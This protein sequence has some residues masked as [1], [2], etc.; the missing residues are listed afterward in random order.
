MPY[1]THNLPL[2]IRANIAAADTNCTAVAL[3]ELPIAFMQFRRIETN[4]PPI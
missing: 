2:K 4:L 1:A 3:A